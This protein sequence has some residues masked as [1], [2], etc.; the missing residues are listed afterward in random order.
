MSDCSAYS[1]FGV[2]YG[3]ECYCG[4]VI[5]TGSVLTTLSDCS[6]ICPGNAYEYCGAGNRLEMYELTSL[7]SSSSAVQSTSSK[8]SSSS[9]IQSTSTTKSSSSSIVSSTSSVVQ[10]T[11]ST[12]SSSSSLVTSSSTTKASTTSTTTS[13]TVA[14]SQ[15]LGIKNNV[16]AYTFQGC[17]TEA[18]NTRALSSASFFDYTAMT[19]EACAADCV[20]YTYFGVEYGGEVRILILTVLIKANLYS[21]IAAMLSTLALFWHLCL[22][23]PSCARVIRTSTVELETDWR[24]TCLGSLQPALQ[25]QQHRKSAAQ[26]QRQ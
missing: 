3:G 5:N 4:D 23:V 19:L 16:G 6:F 7:V 15:T 25:A 8:T 17:Y 13:S 1:H 12:K 18:T 26:A 20:G 21:A 11:S 2:E 14:A 9:T 22:I 10:T 24:C